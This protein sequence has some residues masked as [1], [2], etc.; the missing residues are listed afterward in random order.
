M[1][2]LARNYMWCPGMDKAIGQ[3][4]KGC[5]SLQLTQ[6]N[7]NTAPLHSWEWPAHPWQRI[8]V[9]VAGPFFEKMF[10]IV[11]DAPS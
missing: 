4:A 10:L 8:H 2:A 9:D 1:K 11:L 3:E 5:S 7:H 6:N